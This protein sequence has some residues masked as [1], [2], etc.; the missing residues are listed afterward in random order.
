[1]RAVNSLE[2]ISLMF[3]TGAVKAVP[4]APPTKTLQIRSTTDDDDDFVHKIIGGTIVLGMIV[5]ISAYHSCMLQ[6]LGVG[7]HSVLQKSV[8]WETGVEGKK[9]YFWRF[10]TITKG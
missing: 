4:T 2:S 8:E 1:M 5:M 3:F 10:F 7:G 9:Y 6:S